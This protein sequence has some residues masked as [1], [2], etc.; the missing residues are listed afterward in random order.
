VLETPPKYIDRSGEFATNEQY[1]QWHTELNRITVTQFERELRALGLRAVAR[2]AAHQSD[3]RVHAR[4][5]AYSFEQLATN[6]LYVS[7]FNRKKKA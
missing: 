1:W 5:A 6:E 4:D 7:C 2:G 3:D